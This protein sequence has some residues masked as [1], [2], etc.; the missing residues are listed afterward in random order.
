MPSSSANVRMCP[1]ASSSRNARRRATALG[2]AAVRQV[3]E[4]AGPVELVP[5]GYADAAA[6][7][8]GSV[9]GLEIHQDGRE[10]GPCLTIHLRLRNSASR[11]ATTWLDCRIPT[12]KHFCLIGSLTSSFALSWTVLCCDAGETLCLQSFCDPAQTREFAK[13]R[14]PGS[15]PWQNRRFLDLEKCE[16]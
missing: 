7:Q 13:L 2:P 3:F 10:L 12:S 4:V 16:N 14:Q 5:Y 15:K 9:A 6:A 1:T 8:S 11:R